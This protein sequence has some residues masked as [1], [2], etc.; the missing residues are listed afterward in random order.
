MARFFVL[1]AVI[2]AALFAAE[3]AGPVQRAVVM[4]WTEALVRISAALITLFDSNVGAFGKIL[5]SNATGFAVSIEAGCNGIEAAIVL[6]AAMLAFPAPWKN[7][8]IGILAGLAAVQA[9]NI[10][11]VVS[12]FYLG[13]WSL[14]AFEWAHLYLW[15]AL[16]MLDVLVVWLIWIRTLPPPSPAIAAIPALDADPKQAAVP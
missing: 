6:I 1:F 2:G 15:Q 10:V 9:L 14:T 4:P 16:I 5:Q 12:L 11:R 8:A 7:R 13:Q 3:L